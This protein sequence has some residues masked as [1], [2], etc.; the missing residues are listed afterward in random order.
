[1]LDFRP[2]RPGIPTVPPPPPPP[3]SAPPCAAATPLLFELL[4]RCLVAGCVSLTR[5]ALLLLLLPPPLEALPGEEA[6]AGE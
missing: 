3:A 4:E 5:L 1:M 6:L 2:F